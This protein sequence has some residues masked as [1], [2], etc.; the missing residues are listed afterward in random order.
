[1]TTVQQIQA[2]RVELS[3]VEEAPWN[4]NAM[5][6]D[7][8][9]QLKA[10][11]KS[12]GPEG[13]DPIDT[14]ALEGKK[15]T[16]DGA[17]RVRAAKQLGWDYLYEIFHPEIAT[18]E[19]ARL[20]NYKRDADRGD[21]D[22]FKLAASFKWFVDQGLTQTQIA[23]KYGVSQEKVSDTLALL[24][25][26][27]EAKKELSIIPHGISASV[28]EVLARQPAAVQQAVA[29][30]AAK[31]A[32]NS[33]EQ[34]TVRDLSWEV[35][36]A[37]REYDRAMALQ[38]ALDDP[39]VKPELRRCP[40]CKADPVELADRW[41]QWAGSVLVVKDQNYHCWCL[42]TGAKPE[43]KR[44]RRSDSSG[45]SRPPQHEKSKVPT[46]RY[47]DATIAFFDSVWPKFD[48]VSRFDYSGEDIAK[49]GSRA[50]TVKAK[51]TAN[52]FAT[53]EGDYG[54]KPAELSVSFEENSYAS[55]DFRVEKGPKVV[56]KFEQNGTNDK[57][58]GTYV[59]GGYLATREDL[60]QLE[61]AAV[62]FLEEYAGLKREDNPDWGRIQKRK[63]K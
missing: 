18:E 34:V 2:V 54:G 29:R 40:E 33:K 35:E 14:C 28:Y 62:T 43:E 25:V 15:Y 13:T 63:A 30:K 8:F 22:P 60:H 41:D 46:D 20:F 38:R 47:V 6:P 21:I 58:F 9:D 39:R 5:T 42:V 31:E 53:V 45:S 27:D 36:E 16:C 56:L 23:K 12:A 11:M 51:G 50:L 7:K 10:D 26:D 24:K 17:H 49:S 61:D 32:K 52:F 48:K 37:R 57:S 1:M 3:A 59:R 4:V 44:E 19:Q 55:I